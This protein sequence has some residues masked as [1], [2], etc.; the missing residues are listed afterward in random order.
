MALRIR[1]IFLFFY[2]NNSLIVNLL[3]FS[4]IK[5][6]SFMNTC[7]GL[8]FVC[9]SDIT[10]ITVFPLIMTD[11]GYINSDIAL[12]ISVSACT[13]LASYI[14]IIIVTMFVQVKP[15]VIFFVAALFMTLAKTGL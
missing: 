8:S 11:K 9:S 2:R 1:R 13:Q 7:I 5:N 4:L 14:I 15:K 10:F 3:D 12:V 6:K